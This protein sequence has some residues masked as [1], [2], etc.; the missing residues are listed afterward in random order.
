VRGGNP[1]PPSAKT[2]DPPPGPG[3]SVTRR[4]DGWPATCPGRL[5]GAGSPGPREDA[6]AQHLVLR[7]ENL[8]KLLSG[9]GGLFGRPFGKAGDEPG[10]IAIDDPR[11]S[12]RHAEWR[13][14]PDGID[15]RDLGS[16]NG[17]FVEAGR[18]AERWVPLR[19]GQWLRFADGEPWTLLDRLPSVE[20][21]AGGTTLDLQA[22]NPKGPWFSVLR[23]ED[24]LITVTITH[25]GKAVYLGSRQAELLYFL[26]A[27]W[28]GK[29]GDATLD[30][31]VLR[32]QLV[33][34]IY[35][36]LNATAFNKLLLDT[37]RRLEALGFP[38]PIHAHDA[39]LRL[40]DSCIGRMDFRD[41]YTA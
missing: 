21:R 38:D 8:V 36:E 19:I 9:E 7:C 2:V 12:R 33:I 23:S 28:F 22:P 6:L 16:R 29:D 24:N 5:A 4:N 14:A 20:Q 39:M 37:R 25:E 10:L 17:T 35:G 41:D 13:R 1:N 34:T 32:A 26:A 18:V 11:I 3:D 30:P 40:G 15:V 27:E 31:W